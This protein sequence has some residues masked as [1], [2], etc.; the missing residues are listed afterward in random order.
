MTTADASSLNDDDDVDIEAKKREDFATGSLT[1]HHD[2]A[3]TMMDESMHLLIRHPPPHR[4]FPIQRDDRTVGAKNGS[5]AG[6]P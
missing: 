1:I 5:G 4:G 6:A 2:N 3:A